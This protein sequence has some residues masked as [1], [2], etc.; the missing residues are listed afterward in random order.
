MQRR[1]QQRIITESIIYEQNT[2][3]NR[4]REKQKEKTSINKK[5]KKKKLFKQH[6]KIFLLC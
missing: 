5:K 3:M 1:K 6:R 2:H 4:N